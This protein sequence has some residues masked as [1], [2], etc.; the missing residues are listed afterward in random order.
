MVDAAV[1]YYIPGVRY[2]MVAA[3]DDSLGGDGIG[4]KKEIETVQDLKG[5]NVAFE[6]GAT[7]QFFL[8]VVLERHGLSQGDITHME[9][10]GSDAGAA[11]IA[12]R[13]DAAVTYEPYLSE[14]RKNEGTRVL[15]D[16]REAPGLIT[17]VIL[18]R[19]DV[20]EERPEA[21]Q[22][23]VNGYFR[24]LEYLEQNREESIKIMADGVGGFLDDPKEFEATLQFVTF[25][26]RAANSAY[27]SDASNEGTQIMETLENAI[28]IWG[29]IKDLED[30]PPP[31]NF[32]D[33]Q[34]V[35]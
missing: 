5:K 26:D 22:A 10:L 24:A 7:A 28:E 4:A 2:K 30:L 34:F 18:F 35:Q 21:V 9:M 29:R 14:M 33:S 13:V 27:F 20:I 6:S 11:L 19:E 8:N 17:D 15:V 16:T 12:G 31:E 23:V 25:L 32:I 1:S 3:F